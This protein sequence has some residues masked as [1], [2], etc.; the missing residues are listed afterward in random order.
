LQ[1]LDQHS[2]A[3]NLA[4]LSSQFAARANRRFEFNESRQPF[5]SANDETLSISVL[6]ISNEDPSLVGIH[7]LRH[8]PTP[9]GS[10]EI[11]SD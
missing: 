7:P 4:S 9:S 5:I 8:Q 2:F 11:I 6:S 1:H 3:K 10:A